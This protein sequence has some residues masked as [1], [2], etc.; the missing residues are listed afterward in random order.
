MVHN[1]SLR[2]KFL[3][4]FVLFFFLILC[5]KY[6]NIRRILRSKYSPTIEENNKIFKKAIE[7]LLKSNFTNNEHKKILELT[8]ENFSQTKTE[9]YIEEWSDYEYQILKTSYNAWFYKIN[10]DG[11]IRINRILSMLPENICDFDTPY[12]RKSYFFSKPTTWSEQLIFHN[13]RFALATLVSSNNADYLEMSRVLL[14]SYNKVMK[15]KVDFIA[16]VIKGYDLPKINRCL[17]EQVGWKIIEVEGIQ[18]IKDSANYHF[19]DT[20]TKIQLANF[21]QYDKIVFIDADCLVVRNIDELFYLPTDFAAGMEMGPS[22]PL[23]NSGVFVIRPSLCLYYTLLDNMKKIDE[24][25]NYSEQDYFNWLMGDK[26]WRVSFYYNAL[27]HIFLNNI[28]LWNK[29]IKSYHKIIHYTVIKPLDGKINE[30]IGLWLNFQNQT[31]QL[32]QPKKCIN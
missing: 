8:F 29:E 25:G 6:Q 27:Q 16:I 5:Y 3:I 30:L 28:K 18:F 24:Y 26:I 31:N 20:F 32:Y 9:K 7:D 11:L 1:S 21:L 12:L 2:F 13:N 19:K 23:I 17:L 14:Y 4:S 15:Q 10:L 22:S